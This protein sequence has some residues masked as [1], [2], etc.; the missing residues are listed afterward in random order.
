MLDNKIF[1]FTCDDICNVLIH[2]KSRFTTGHPTDTGNTIYN[3]IVMSLTGFQF[4][5]FRILQSGRPVTHFVVIVDGN[6]IVR[7]QTYYMSVLNEYTRYTVNCGGNDVFVI[8][9]YIL[10]IRLYQMIE[11]RTT[12]GAESQP[13]SYGA[14]SI[15]FCLE[16]ISHGDTGCVDNQLRVTRSDSRV[17]LPPRIHTCQQTEAGRSTGRGSS[18][19]IGKLYTLSGKT[20]DIRSTYL[21]SAI[22]TQIA[23]T[24]IVGN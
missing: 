21:G 19:G 15:A 13:F 20:V 23:D 16:H 22:A 5:K 8:K 24:Q 6:G 4:Y 14:G 18:I 1:C 17:F 7:I 12:F 9:S 3:R 11:V 10:S 2:P